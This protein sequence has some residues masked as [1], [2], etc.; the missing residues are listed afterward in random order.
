MDKE[1]FCK[2]L[3]TLTEQ[4]LLDNP[5]HRDYANIQQYTDTT[6]VLAVYE[7]YEVLIGHT[8]GDVLDVGC[9]VG[10]AKHINPTI[11][12]TNLANDYFF[13]V[14][15]ALDVKKDYWC[16]NCLVNPKWIQTPKQFD[17]VILHRFLPWDGDTLA[18]EV[19]YNMLSGVHHVLKDGGTLLYTPINAKAVNV[20][21]WSL[22][23]ST[24]LPTFII[25]KEQIHN[26]LYPAAA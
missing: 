14:E 13:C 20:G 18:S 17:F 15:K 8:Y 16:S 2:S 10:F 21:G 25:T 12:T 4:F 6:N 5:Q 7:Q 23:D 11:H 9:G 19:R 1:L 26:E 3:T 24:S 22:M